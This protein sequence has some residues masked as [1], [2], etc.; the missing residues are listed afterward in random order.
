VGSDKILPLLEFES[1]V[2]WTITQSLYSLLYTGSR[3]KY[4]NVGTHCKNW[5]QNSQSTMF[6]LYKL[7]LLLQKLVSQSLPYAL[8]AF[9]RKSQHFLFPPW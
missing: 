2:I 1:P 3:E 4:K 6:I 8:G 7:L 5:K 9:I